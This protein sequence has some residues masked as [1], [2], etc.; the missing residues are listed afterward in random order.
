MANKEMI[1]TG[2]ELAENGLRVAVNNA[3]RE[4]P[5]WSGR[6]YDLFKRW[7]NK[8]PAGY[9]F[10]MEAFRNDCYEYKMIEKPN[11]LRAFGMVT[12]RAKKEGL[13]IQE[14]TG[15]CSS[16]KSHAANAAMLVKV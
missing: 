2:K 1:L 5:N 9:R 16:V 8:K 3:N 11:S 7:I 15:Q 13:I 14:G 10:M 6:C 4:F 12:K